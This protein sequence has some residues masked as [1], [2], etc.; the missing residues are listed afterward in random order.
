MT[1]YTGEK[2]VTLIKL[3]MAIRHIIKKLWEEKA[4]WGQL[5]C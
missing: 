5:L 4:F 3:Q 1:L 2:P